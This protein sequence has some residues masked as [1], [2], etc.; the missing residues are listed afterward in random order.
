M[1][2]IFATMLTRR[3]ILSVLA[4]AAFAMAVLTMSSAIALETTDAVQTE[5]DSYEN[6]L[7]R[8]KSPAGMIPADPQPVGSEMRFDDRDHKPLMGSGPQGPM[9]NI[10]PMG[11]KGLHQPMDDKL[12]MSSPEK[13]EYQHDADPE[14]LEAHIKPMIDG[15]ITE[16]D[17]GFIEDTIDYAESVGMYDVAAELRAKLA[18]NFERYLRTSSSL[19]PLNT[20]ASGLD[21]DDVDESADF[22]FVEE[23]DDEEV[24]VPFVFEEP[25]PTFFKPFSA[26]VAPSVIQLEL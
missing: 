5:D 8:P 16:F 1:S 12:Q 25:L 21:D 20:R 17:P 11:P 24:P 18:A 19:S 2:L 6:D 9:Q 23:E 7:F 15:D 14:T 3:T 13:P 10:T 26:P 22:I 4:I